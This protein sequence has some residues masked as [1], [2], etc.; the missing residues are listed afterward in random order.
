MKIILYFLPLHTNSISMKKWIILFLSI[1]HSLL[2]SQIPAYKNPEL[3][4]GE[5][6]GNLLSLMTLEEK[7]G[8][9]LCPLG[10]EMYEKKGDTITHSELFEEQ[11]QQF[12]TG[13][14]W[15]VYRADPWT[16][17]TIANGLNPRTAAE[18]GNAMQ[19][20]AIENSRWGIP[21]FIAEEAPHGHMAIGTTV[22]PTGIGQAATWNPALLEKMGEIIAKEI[23]CQGAH[24]SYGPVLDLSRDPRWSRVEES[25]GEDAVLTGKLAAAIV[26]GCGSGDLSNSH[27]TIVTLKHF[28]AYGVP[29]SGKNGAAAQVGQR[30][31]HEHFLPPFKTAI[32]AGALSVMTGYNSIDGIPCTSNSYLLTDILLRN[33]NF[34]G[35]S[36]SDLGSIEGLHSSHFVAENIKMAAKL[37]AQAG[38]HADLGGNAYKHLVEAVKNGEMEE[39]VIDSAVYR[40]LKVKF[41]M[42]LFE[43]PYVN[44]DDAAQWVGSTQHG[45]VA[46]DVA[47]ESIVLLKNNGILPLNR[48]QNIAVIGPNANNI[49]NLLGDYT[50]PQAKM[51][52]IFESIEEIYSENEQITNSGKARYAKGCAVRDTTETNIPEAMEVASKADVIV[53]VVGGSSARDFKTSY[54]E[55]GAAVVDNSILSDMECGEGFDRATLDLLGDQLKLL[56]MLK[57]LGK[58]LV[59][60]YIQGRPLNMNWAAENADALLTAWY[61]GQSGGRAIA[62]VLFGKY[63][64]AGRLPISVPRDEGQIPVYYNKKNPVGG[65]YVEM[66]AKPLYPFGYGLSYTTF[67]YENLQIEQTGIRSFEVTFE[68]SNTGKYDGDEVIQ[69]YVKDHYASVAR[70]EKQLRDFQRL[71]L[72]IG[73]TKRVRFTLTEEDFSIIDQ[74]MKQIVEPGMFTIMIGSSSEAIRLSGELK[75]EKT[76]RAN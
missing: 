56:K 39:T 9:L 5:R 62:E 65:D 21:I 40:I 64:P 30:E 69:L 25:Y 43:N 1:S 32:D 35:F 74:N 46:A 22:F 61:P 14:F 67:A 57:T 31:L 72:K 33:W 28:A 24:I 53:A 54:Q 18:A 59:V 37:A 13:M 45:A 38:L 29:E 44:P 36:I 47:K 6:T 19:K 26:K 12:H 55:T 23:R 48:L 34:Q 63:N 73:E 27:S 51:K 3:T 68:I 58:P 71:H 8:Q 2:F 15:A 4:A 7:V 70:A 60:I 50:A 16:R 41:E 11:I 20:H 49:Y 17:K 76:E 66:S 52:T 42:G 10:W 75:I